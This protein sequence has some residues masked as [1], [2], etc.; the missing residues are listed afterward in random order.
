[1]NMTTTTSTTV[2]VSPDQVRALMRRLRAERRVVV[3]AP[4][5]NGNY[6]VTY[7]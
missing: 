2:E 1:M 5:S 6:Q 3:S 7:R 4:V